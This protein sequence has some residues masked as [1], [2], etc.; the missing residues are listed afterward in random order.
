[1]V[2]PLC[3][4]P[5]YAIAFTILRATLLTILLSRGNEAASNLNVW[6]QYFAAGIFEKV[7]S[8]SALCDVCYGKNKNEDDALSFWLT[9]DRNSRGGC[10]TQHSFIWG[11]FTTRS[12][13]L[14]L[15]YTFFDRKDTLLYP[16]YWPYSH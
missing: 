4:E 9:L 16:F 7:G 8:R 13:P 11:G 2:R 14:T 6:Q 1:M 15:W 12:N 10:S 3:Y 5:R